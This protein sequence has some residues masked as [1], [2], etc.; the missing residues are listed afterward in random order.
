ML[1]TMGRVRSSGWNRAKLSST[2]SSSASLTWAADTMSSRL[3][4]GLPVGG[5]LIRRAENWA[6]RVKMSSTSSFSSTLSREVRM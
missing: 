4:K 5:A 3:R 2:S 1:E 6:D